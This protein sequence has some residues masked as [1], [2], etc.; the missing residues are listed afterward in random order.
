MA[1][2]N[3][4]QA[5][6]S[7]IQNFATKP[8]DYA[9]PA[10]NTIRTE[11]ARNIYNA[12]QVSPQEEARVRA[13]VQKNYPFA[14]E[15]MIPSPKID[16]NALYGG[17]SGSGGSGYGGTS[18][19]N[20]SSGGGKVT[21]DSML[22]TAADSFRKMISEYEAKGKEFDSKNP[23]V[24]SDVLNE[25]RK[26]VGARLDPYYTQLLDDFV[27]GIN[28]KRSRSVEDEKSILNEITADTDTF[29]G[30]QKRLTDEALG[31]AAEGF[32]D[33]GMFFSGK[34]LKKEGDINVVSRDTTD[35]FL[36]GQGR[37][38]D[39][40][41]LRGSRTLEDLKTSQDLGQRDI[42]QEKTFRIESEGLKEAELARA[43]REFEKNQYLGGSFAKSAMDQFS[44]N[45]QSFI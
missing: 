23:F 13:E 15:P 4:I 8:N 43:Q 19:Y 14:F 45:F 28:V 30:R 32:A 37:K 2:F 22:S 21:A 7:A 24:F 38:Q 10:A 18:Q 5:I 36:T 35:D 16:Y 20:P 31:S 27:K 42:N 41:N 40:S 39:A 44:T 17:S 29:T 12:A 33:S 6:Q 26:E 25:K 34:R 9:G 3:P 1:I 11:Q